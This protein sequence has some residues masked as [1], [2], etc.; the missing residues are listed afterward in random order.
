MLLSEQDREN[1]PWC[2]YFILTIVDRVASTLSPERF[3]PQS[4]P[5]ADNVLGCRDCTMKN[6]LLLL[7]LKYFHQ[8]YSQIT[9]LKRSNFIS[10]H[11]IF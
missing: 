8:D 9:R 4:R 11:E 7:L 2:T 1:I 10:H 3:V 5:L 6:I